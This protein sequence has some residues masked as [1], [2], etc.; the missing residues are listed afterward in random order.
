MSLKVSDNLL[1]SDDC[2]TC[3]K[4]CRY[5]PDELMDAPM[6]TEDQKE[7]LQSEFR[8]MD[9]RFEQIGKLWR[10]MLNDISGSEKKICP[11]Y[12]IESGHCEGYKLEIFDCLTWPFYIMRK[13]D[14]IFITVS[15]DCP[16]MGRH[17]TEVL[18]NYA[19]HHIGPKMVDAAE[20]NPDLITSLH[21]NVEILCNINET[22]KKDEK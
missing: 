19:L 8:I 2:F 3:K 22:K 13:G 21:G 6:F 14:D 12:D 20:V 18:K 5:E 9:I 16:T 4:C 11:L 7:K 10:I 15:N 17:D 1:T